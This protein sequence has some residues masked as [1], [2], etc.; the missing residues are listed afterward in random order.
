MALSVVL[1]C[2][3]PGACLGSKPSSDSFDNLWAGYL[4]S[5]CLSLHTCNMEMVRVSTAWACCVD[6]V[7]C[8]WNSS[9]NLRSTTYTFVMVITA[10][11]KDR[12]LSLTESGFLGF[13]GATFVCGFG[14][15]PGSQF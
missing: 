10:P 1:R 4:T 12:G 6:R 3:V 8:I 7:S 11:V 15:L 2:L 14:E 13:P 5:W 9:W